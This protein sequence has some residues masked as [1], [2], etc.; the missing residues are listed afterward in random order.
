LNW[1][2]EANVFRNAKRIVVKIG[3]SSLTHQDG[4][5]NLYNVEGFVRQIVD[6]ANEGKEVI[7]ITSG[8]IGAGIGRLGLKSKP[9]SIPEKQAAAA[10]G[11]GILMQIY[12]KLFGE[13]GHTVAQILLTREDITDR[14]R[15]LNARN[16]LI[17]LLRYEVIPIINENDTIATDEIDF[18][19]NDTLGALVAGLVD[20]NL[21]IILSDVDGVYDADPRVNPQAKLLSEV[22]DV[23]EEII[24]AAGGAGTKMG[25]GGMA[26][27]IQAARIVMRLGIPMVIAHSQHPDV[28]RKVISGEEIGTVFIPPNPRLDMRKRWIAFFQTPYGEVVV[29]EGAKKALLEQG[30]SLLSAGVVEVKGVFASGQLVKVLDQNGVE[31]ARG[32][33]N[34]SSQEISKI[35]GCSIQDIKKEFNGKHS[36]EVIHRDNLVVLQI[37]EV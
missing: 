4:K 37:P 13:Y 36:Y 2:H 26:T 23:T 15:H 7:I 11:Q 19:D 21:L 31:L 25:R 20:A 24:A 18:G 9:K 35:K 8:A 12:E 28:I 29:D 22:T 34:Y 10:V 16:A 27:K 14:K 6:L 17:T 30:K 1:I 33:V 5:L 32:I 3:T